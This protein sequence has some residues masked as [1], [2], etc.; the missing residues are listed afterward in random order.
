[1]K[2]KKLLSVILAAM[3]ITAAGCSDNSGAEA[4][5]TTAAEAAT[6]TTAAETTTEAATTE[7]T[8]TEAETT[9]EATE[10]PADNP[11]MTDEIREFIEELRAEAPIYAD[12]F[13]KSS[14]IPVTMAFNQEVDLMGTGEISTVYMELGMASFDSF[15]VST[16]TLGSPMDII[17]TDGKYYMVSAAEKTALY[18]EMSAEEAAEMQ[19]SMTASVKASFDASA[20]KYETGETEF[21]DATYLYEKI[22]TAEMGEIMV[23]ADPATKEIKYLVS[24]GV[25]M[26][27]VTISDKVDNSKLEIPADY[28]LIDMASM[29]GADDTNGSEPTRD[30]ATAAADYLTYSSFSYNGLVEQ[31]EFEGYS[32]EE[33]VAAVDACG[34]D[35][36]EQAAK[37]AAT[38][39]EYSAFSYT[40]LIGQLEFEGFTT[41]QA[42][43]AVD[44]CN[45]D[46]NE[47]AVKA[48]KEYLDYS[49][50]TREELLTQLEFEGFTAEQAVYGVEANGL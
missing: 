45:A 37:S 34:A 21:R 42:T 31:L 6:T 32:H 44:N 28:T 9:T 17:I 2:M 8:T 22:T 13:E 25:T 49:E 38:Y 46:W 23:Y 29:M 30:A 33:A 15:Y 40:G 27:I 48:A 12:F 26:E 43:K 1:M 11:L 16:D 14:S 3:V 19:E 7:A 41:E 39:L 24:Q 5:T 18:M 20:A 36:D 35:W 50:F 4:T 10:A 47:Q